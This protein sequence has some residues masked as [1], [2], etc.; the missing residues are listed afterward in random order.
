M[1][2]MIN[3]E[4]EIKRLARLFAERQQIKVEVYFHRPPG[5]KFSDE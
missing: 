5:E 3:I 1:N 2:K 4:F